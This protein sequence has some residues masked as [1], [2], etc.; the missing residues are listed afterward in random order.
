MAGNNISEDLNVAVENF[1]K[2][3]ADPAYP[4]DQIVRYVHKKGH[5]VWLR[6]RG[7]AIRDKTG[8][9]VRMLGIHT[10]L[11]HLKEN[12]EKLRE[13]EELHRI[14]ME[15]ILDPVFITDDAGVITFACPNIPH[16]L[17]YSLDEI[18]TM[19]N[20]SAILGKSRPKT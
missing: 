4:Y 10:D 2:H 7:I 13:S 20:I 18:S 8:N 11:T 12:E 5:T 6:C 17:G 14:T 16:L 15:N 3:C 19:A 9:P 1:K